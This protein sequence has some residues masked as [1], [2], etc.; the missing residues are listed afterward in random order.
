MDPKSMTT[1]PHHASAQTHTLSVDFAWSN[2]KSLVTDASDESKTPLYIVSC[3]VLTSNLTFK[4]GPDDKV[5]GTS[6]VHAISISPDY[7]LHGVKGTLQAQ[8]RLRTIYSHTSTIFSDS[9]A[10]VK[11]TWTSQ[12]GFKNWDFICVDEMQQP[13]AKFSASLWNPKK[14]ATIEILGPKAHDVRA[15][16]EIVLVGFTLYWCMVV[17]MNNPLN[18]LGSVFMSTEKTSEEE[19]IEKPTRVGA[20]SSG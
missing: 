11:M 15:R 13:V 6:S 8:H 10:P 19:Q 4:T 2:F 16:D 14:W 9:G 17:R 7:E 12:S 20:V 3:N 1:L 18:L 5:M